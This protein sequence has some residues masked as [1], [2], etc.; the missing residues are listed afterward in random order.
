MNSNVIIFI[1]EIL[2]SFIF[3][4]S[5][6]KYYAKK[7][8]NC[9]ISFIAKYTFLSMFLFIIFVPYDIEIS[10]YNSDEEIKKKKLEFIKSMITIFFGLIYFVS[11]IY[12]WFFSD[13]IMFYENSP[14][15]NMCSRACGAVVDMIL[16]L[17][18]KG[19]F[20]IL[21]IIIFIF[22]IPIFLFIF[23]YVG[24]EVIDLT[25]KILILT[26]F[27]GIIFFIILIGMSLLRLPKDIY[28]R[29]DFKSR[30]NYLYKRIGEIDIKLNEDQNII[31]DYYIELDKTIKNYDKKKDNSTISKT[32][33][34]ISQNLAFGVEGKSRNLYNEILKNISNYEIDISQEKINE[35]IKEKENEK[36]EEDYIIKSTKYL[37]K[38]NQANREL[39]SEIERLI[40]LRNECYNEWLD[41]KSF[42][43]KNKN[44]ALLIDDKELIIK[45]I[46]FFKELLYKYSK[47]IS[48]ILVI[49]ILILNIGIIVLEFLY[50][51]SNKNIR[52]SKSDDD[53]FFY[54]NPISKI[55]IIIPFFYFIF[56]SLYTVFSF[57]I[58]NDFYYYKKEKTDGASIMYIT[59]ILM[60]ISAVACVHIINILNLSIDLKQTNIE[61]FM[62]F[63]KNK[64]GKEKIYQYI[65]IFSFILLVIIAIL[66]FFDVPKK[67]MDKCYFKKEAIDESELIE[68]GKKIMHSLNMKENISNISNEF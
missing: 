26:S 24:N 20:I 56:L 60:R 5:T 17:I 51:F 9:L 34:N 31:F 10:Y 68:R 27:P 46:P 41:K 2:F 16:K 58:E 64:N 49:F 11:L 43:T 25:Q 1:F 55:F 39:G 8:I 33:T 48:I 14:N 3:V 30:I 37:G 29:F 61:N 36:K 19:I 67:L 66:N 28:Y 35:R 13:Y 47:P 62:G 52:K 6:Y 59:K 53:L 42:L 38:I 18:K 54:K 45:D 15:F 21:G 65:L 7:N 23:L 50:S 22:L 40:G 12:G 44:N 57:G 4:I 32:L 63:K